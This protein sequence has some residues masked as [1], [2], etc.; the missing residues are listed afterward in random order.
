MRKVV[1]KI[2]RDEF[3]V[4]V[5]CVNMENGDILEEHVVSDESI[6]IDNV[7]IHWEAEGTSI[8]NSISVAYILVSIVAVVDHN[9]IAVLAPNIIFV[10]S[11]NVHVSTSATVVKVISAVVEVDHSA[12]VEAHVLNS[13]VAFVSVE[14]AT[15]VRS[16][17]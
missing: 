14:S 13:S 5:A 9:A 16:R 10:A 11:M 2:V 6:N 15:A 7:A 12:S 8:E 4:I 3:L 1:I 17:V